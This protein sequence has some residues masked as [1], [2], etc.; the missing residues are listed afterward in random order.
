[1]KK[2]KMKM[3]NLL[4]IVLI[5][6]LALTSCR[7]NRTVEYLSK[8]FTVK[9]REHKKTISK[10]Y[11]SNLIGFENNDSTD[12]FYLFSSPIYMTNNTKYSVCDNTIIP[13]SDTKGYMFTN[14]IND[15]KTYLPDN[16]SSQKSICIEN[17]NTKMNIFLESIESKKA[18]K[19]IY[20]S[21]FNKENERVFYD[22]IHEDNKCYVSIDDFGV[23]TELIINND[24]STIEYIIEIEGMK[25]ESSCPDYILFLDVINNDVKGIV[26]KPEIFEQEKDILNNI[27]NKKC[28]FS[29]KRIETN[30]YK[31]V[32]TINDNIE[33]PIKINQSFH[34][35]KNKQPD[36]ATYSNS[37]SGYYLNDK[38]ILGNDIS[39]GEG[40]LLVRFEDLDLIDIKPQ[41]IIFAEYIISEISDTN[42]IATIVMYPVLSSWC[43]LNVRWDTK[44]V[45]S[46]EYTQEVTVKEA[47]D[48]HFDITEIIKKWIENKG[49]KEAEYSIQH[50]FALVNKTPETPKIFAT[51]DHGTFT[52]C[53]KISIK[54]GGVL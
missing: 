37:N 29:I 49:E 36:S 47:G 8:D 9:S 24:I 35:Y 10:F 18:E 16:I 45:Y 39:K 43:S 32:V 20:T 21:V 3:T 31:L 25:I 38:V 11:N 5:L 23:N 50:G 40:Q 14:K 4:L 7:E 19:V 17:S 52:S 42:Q 1:M 28:D 33:Y 41:D 44:P 13:I 48:Y 22:S 34:L 15:I 30:R 51:G 12:T 53:I 26:Y 54:S 2:I 27:M 6:S 46:K